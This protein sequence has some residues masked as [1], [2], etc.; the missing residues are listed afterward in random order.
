MD[1]FVK[2]KHGEFRTLHVLSFGTFGEFLKSNAGILN[3][4]P[5]K[6]KERDLKEA[7]DLAQAQ[8]V[9]WTKQQKKMSP[10]N[11]KE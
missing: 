8:K 9:A 11:P 3:D 5:E 1:E 7:W 4:L 6:E 2:F 10:K